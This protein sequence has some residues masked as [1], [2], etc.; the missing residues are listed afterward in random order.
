[1]KESH[2]YFATILGVKAEMLEALDAGMEGRTG[3]KEVF[4]KLFKENEAA[5][6]RVFASREKEPKDAEGA[7]KILYEVIALHE[8]Q[9]LSYLKTQKGETDFEKAAHLAKRIGKVG[10]GFFLKTAYAE[11]ILTARPP[12][13]LLK[14]LGLKDVGELFSRHDIAEAMSA[15]RFMETDEW[16]HETFEEAYSGFTPADFEERE[17]AIR[18]L[19]S[20]WHEVAK[21]F[22][23]KKHHNVSHL[24]EFGVIF[25]NPIAEDVAGKFLRDLALLLHYLHEV[26]FYAK[27][28]RRYAESKD[29]AAHLKALLRGDVK[30]VGAMKE[31]EWLIVQRYLFKENPNDPRL[32]L[33]RVNPESL[34]WMRGERDLARL[35][36]ERK[37]IDL[38]LWGNL[39]WVSGLFPG[40][41][42]PVSFDL[43][44]SAMSEV[45]F[46]EG[47]REFFSY[48]QR[49]ALWTKLFLEYAGG[50]A[51]TERLLVEYFDKG[52]IAF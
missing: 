5:I 36:K 44:D 46:K 19:G 20:E 27:L 39:D 23:K 11:K 25:I 24:K 21:A 13:N 52:V 18:V 14:F 17:I 42:D 10:S 40:S 1:M 6:R 2:A 49:E 51:E 37:D 4:E 28:F 16:M 33:P 3:K 29:F 8:A 30:E 12:R 50:E 34:H 35:G 32:F 41:E 45:S 38:E 48:H 15:L 26:D 7:R 22:V 47:K 43:E 9:L 31:G